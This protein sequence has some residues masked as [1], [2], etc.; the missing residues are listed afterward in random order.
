MPVSK[1]FNRGESRQ[2]N[3][4][5][6]PEPRATLAEVV[7]KRISAELIDPDA[8]DQL[9]I[10]SGGILRELIRLTNE[11]CR[12]C[13]RLIR[14]NPDDNSI[15][16]NSEIVEQAITKLSLDFDTRI[17][18]ADY[19]ILAKT[20]HNFRPDDPKDQRFLDLL[21]GL[22]V[23]EYRNGQLWYDVHPIVMGLLQQQG[24]I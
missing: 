17:G 1:L 9:I 23:L 12:I 22:Y 16:I 15:K 7:N 6:N 11:C 18:T 21:H 14:R 20:Y 8:I 4:V 3:P 5:P 24:A 10:S 2:A 13:L 19:D